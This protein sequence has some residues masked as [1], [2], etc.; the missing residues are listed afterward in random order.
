MGKTGVGPPPIASTIMDTGVMIL[1]QIGLFP[2]YTIDDSIS[3]TIYLT[4]YVCGTSK[5]EKCM[6]LMCLLSSNSG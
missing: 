2:P 6:L 3:R 4:N 1:L 5:N